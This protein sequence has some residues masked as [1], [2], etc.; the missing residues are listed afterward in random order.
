MSKDKNLNND[1]N[2]FKNA[3]QKISE[4]SVTDDNMIDD[5]AIDD[6]DYYDEDEDIIVM[7]DKNGIEKEFYVVGE[8]E[9]DSYIYKIVIERS[10]INDLDN[11]DSDLEDMDEQILVLKQISVDDDVEYE[12]VEEDNLIE[13]I[14]NLFESDENFDDEDQE[15]NDF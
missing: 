14:I 1:E 13:K 2:N 9:Y 15:E 10:E 8:V 6:D 3:E 5:N 11:I 12:Y 7:N 4:N